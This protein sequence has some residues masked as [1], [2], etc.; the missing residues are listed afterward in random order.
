[1]PHSR[2]DRLAFTAQRLTPWLGL[3]VVL[4]LLI[5]QAY[6]S[7]WRP[8]LQVDVVTYQR[9]ALTYLSDSSW[10]ALTVNEYQ[11]GA[12]CPARCSCRQRGGV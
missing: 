5:S 10:G 7:V 1:M 2:T 6:A 3:I 9:R 12:L 4:A 11:P 8:H